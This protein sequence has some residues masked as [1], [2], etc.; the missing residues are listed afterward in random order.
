VRSWGCGSLTYTDASNKQLGAVIVQEGKPLTFYSRKL[1]SAQT[2]YTTGEQELLS[3]VETLKEFIDILLGQQVIVHTDHLNILYGKLSN[4]RITRWRL[5]LEESGPTYVHIAGK[6][7]IVADAL[8]RLEK[9][10]SLSETEEGLVLSHA[11]TKHDLV[12]H[13]MNVD[14]MESEEFPMSPEIIAREQKKYTHLK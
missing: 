14:E 7:N 10:E 12:H 9:D 3:I 1:N 13:I 8:S 5:L 4:D 2:R 11:I 6:N